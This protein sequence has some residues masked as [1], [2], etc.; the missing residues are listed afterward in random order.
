M[1]MDCSRHSCCPGT[2]CDSR[3]TSPWRGPHGPQ[4]LCVQTRLTDIPA[5]FATA[6]WLSCLFTRGRCCPSSLFAFS[7]LPCSLFTLLCFYFF[8][9]IPSLCP[10]LFYPF[11]LLFSLVLTLSNEPLFLFLVLHCLFL[12]LFIRDWH[13]WLKPVQ[14]GQVA[15]W[16]RNLGESDSEP[17]YQDGWVFLALR[18]LILLCIQT[19]PMYVIGSYPRIKIWWNHWPGQ[20]QGW[21]IPCRAEFYFHML[22]NPLSLIK[23]QWKSP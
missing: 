11:P 10:T 15:E 7:F 13:S 18:H 1:R 21:V 14:S 17:S 5:G 20:S 9:P 4:S 19:L 12:N 8:Q 16:D 3:S 6:D 22:G 23:P 2:S